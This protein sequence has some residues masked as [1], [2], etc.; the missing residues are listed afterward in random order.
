MLSRGMNVKASIVPVVD[1]SDEDVL[2]HDDAIE[3]EMPILPVMDQVLFP[4]VLIPIAAQRLKS[5]Q[6]LEAVDGT[7]QHIAVFPQQTKN[8]NPSEVDLYPVGVVAKV[9]RVFNV[10]QDGTVAVGL[11]VMRC[12]S[13]AVTSRDP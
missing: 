4:G 8:D 12:H 9:L 2:L 5:R 6:L 3:N 11:G 10:L 13:L 1:D 7:G